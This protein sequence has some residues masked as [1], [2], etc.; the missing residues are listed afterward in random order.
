M[1]YAPS[2]NADW[3]PKGKRAVIA[4]TVALATVIMLISATSGTGALYSQNER[5]GVAFD[6]A[7]VNGTIAS[8]DYSR[9]GRFGWYIDGTSDYPGCPG[10][11]ETLNGSVIERITVVGAAGVD[12]PPP[13]GSA[14]AI[15]QAHPDWYPSGSVW[16]IGN[17][18]GYDC[19]TRTPYTADVTNFLVRQYAQT[20]H[21]WYD[22][23]KQLD[24][25]YR[26]M[27]GAI[28]PGQDTGLRIDT[29]EF[30]ARLFRTYYDLYSE[31]MP[32]DVFNLRPYFAGQGMNVARLK[33]AVTRFRQN[34]SNVQL[35]PGVTVD[36]SDSELWLTA[37]GVADEAATSEQTCQMLTEC[38]DWLC[39]RAGDDIFNNQ[40]GLAT[41]DGRL[42]QRW[43]WF[44]LDGNQAAFRSTRLF[45]DHTQITSV[46]LQ[47]A[48]YCS[49][50]APEPTSVIILAAAILLAVP[51]RTTRRRPRT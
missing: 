21:Q 15:R 44:T 31:A 24:P 16:M 38:T 41:D 36:Y 45:N 5:F 40:I 28:V 4:R 17:E 33:A 48:E 7:A 8:Y 3:G 35:A 14:A 2:E 46:G 30:L 1:Q 11:L 32:V 6:Q 19:Y 29:T 39:G 23:I 25:S 10:P 49:P 18:I 26:V 12:T 42:V 20:Y 9:L 34:I 50:A 37:Y 51:V 27:L 22:Q 13:S 47:Y 43:A